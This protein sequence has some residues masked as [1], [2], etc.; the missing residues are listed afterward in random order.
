MKQDELY[1][2]DFTIPIFAHGFLL[3]QSYIIFDDVM[4]SGGLDDWKQISD[5][6]LWMDKHCEYADYDLNFWYS[7][8][9]DRWHCTAYAIERDEEGISYTNGNK[10]RRLW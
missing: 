10:F 1:I 7:E 5:V 3:A 4:E 9:E 2:P 6:P 8:E